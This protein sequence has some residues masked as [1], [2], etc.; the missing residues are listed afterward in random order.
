MNFFLLVFLDKNEFA[1]SNQV[2]HY[3]ELN[4]MNQYAT[5]RSDSGTAQSAQPFY[6]PAMSAASGLT[7]EMF[8]SHQQ[9]FMFP[10]HPVQQMT[11][12]N[13]HPAI[14]QSHIDFYNRMIFYQQQCLFFAQQRQQKTLATTDSDS[15]SATADSHLAAQKQQTASI[16]DD[17][18]KAEK[19]EAARAPQ[20]GRRNNV[21]RDQKAS[22]KYEK[23]QSFPSHS[24]S[25]ASVAQLASSSPA[26]SSTSSSG[27]SRY[28]QFERVRY[29][30]A[31][32]SA[33]QT[34][35]SELLVAP[36]YL[37]DAL[38]QKSR[39]FNSRAGRPYD[40]IDFTMMQLRRAA[41]NQ[42]NHGE[43]T[44]NADTALPDEIIVTVASENVAAAIRERDAQTKQ[45][46]GSAANTETCESPTKTSENT[47]ASTAATAETA[48]VSSP[49]SESAETSRAVE[50]NNVTS[51]EP[52]EKTYHFSRMQFYNSYDF[53]SELRTT[54]SS[55]LRDGSMQYPVRVFN[56]DK[57]GI[58]ISIGLPFTAVI[59]KRD[60]EKKSQD[61]EVVSVDSAPSTTGLPRSAGDNE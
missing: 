29:A 19:D 43:T 17:L 60:E 2:A 27:A 3:A 31:L 54:L 47:V 51:A 7:S 53:Q 21:V 6:A 10:M 36:Q 41:L 45:L 55:T 39:I 8:H 12:Q 46:D 24:Y 18:S 42:A 49:S 52:K 22:K 61:S 58:K 35:L 16:R 44:K 57:F 13:V 50:G 1:F 34:A 5:L 15:D 56:H 9:H 37:R 48:A 38:E 25:P 28:N 23:K 30:M 20:R 4:F 40:R 11:A 59:A 14:I 32:K 26:S 33:R